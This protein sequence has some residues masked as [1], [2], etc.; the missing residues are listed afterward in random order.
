MGNE[1]N[2]SNLKDTKIR[3]LIFALS[4]SSLFFL[5]EVIGGIV[6]KSLALISDAAH[7]LTDI[8]ALTIALVAIQIAKKAADTLRTF[9]YYRFEILAAAFNTILLFMVAVYIFYE[10][11][12]RLWQPPEIQTIG[13]LVVASV[14]LIV[15]LLSMW[16]L[17]S[18]KDSN[19]SMKSAHLEV[20]SDMIG[21]I[22]VIIGAL[23]IKFTGFKWVDSA[24]AI[25]MALWVLP[26]TW[27]LLKESINILLEGVPK[28]INLRE[29][30]KTLLE[31]KSVLNVHELHVWAIAS[32]KICLTA[33]VIIEEKSDC[34]GVLPIMREIL[35]SQFGILHTTFQH[36]RKICLNEEV[37]CHFSKK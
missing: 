32:G 24:I 7:M 8:M 20:W 9:G 6:T 12:Q 25:M 34:E 27:I 37:F 33:H 14:G 17:T 30:E 1:H 22:G 36:E 5:V 15:N 31:I 19:L 16:L 29:I 23:I 3:P 10:A 18:H 2:H 21:S 4:L 11:Y 26:R 28:G 35:A 13:M